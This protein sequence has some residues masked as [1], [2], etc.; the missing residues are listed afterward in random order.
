MKT[1]SLSATRRFDIDWLRIMLIFSVFLFHIGMFFNSFGW[2]VKNNEII[3]WLD[4]IMAWLHRW[5]MPLLFMVSGVGTYYALGKR[6]TGNFIGERARRL[7]IPLVFGMLVIVPPQVW[8]EKQAEFGSFINFLPHMFEGSYPEGNMSWHHLWFV[9]YLF[10]CAMAALPFIMIM[11]S[12]TGKAIY[13]YLEKFFAV[14]GSFLIMTIPLYLSMEFLLRYFPWETHALINDWAYLTYNF[15]FF[16]SG[17]V[18]MS[19]QKI[20]D[21]LMQQRRLYAAIALAMTGVFFFDFFQS[22]DP[23]LNESIQLYLGALLEFSIA[24]TVLGYGARYLNRDHRWRKPLNE[25]IYPFYILHQTAIV[26]IGL[27]LISL[28]LLPWAKAAILTFGSLMLTIGIYLIIRRLNL[29]RLL[30][31]MRIRKNAVQRSKDLR[32][33]RKAS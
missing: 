27:Y 9:L 12:G 13:C 29:T 4:P 7:L 15:I 22:V 3:T 5:R 30:F 6:S 11:R 10:I 26:L 32:S 1:S 25:A 17:Y 24:L 21:L 33:L 2:H 31:G 23:W 19:N 8:A 18:L 14:P 20:I 28:P 16:L